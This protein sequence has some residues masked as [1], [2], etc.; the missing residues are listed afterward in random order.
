MSLLSLTDGKSQTTRWNYDEYGRVTNKLDRAGTEVLRYKYD[1]DSRLTNRWSIEK[2]N[3]Y[4]AHDPVGNLTTI[5]YPASPDVSFSYDAL[6]RTP[7]A[8]RL[9]LIPLATNS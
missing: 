1:A 5:D 9:M 6:N 2:G 8:P 4:F 7:R 3:T